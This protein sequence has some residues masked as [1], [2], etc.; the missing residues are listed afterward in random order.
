MILQNGTVFINKEF[1]P[2]DI[3]VENGKITAIMPRET[4]RPA[5]YK[6][7]AVDCTNKMIWPGLFDIHTHGCMGF[8][9]SKSEPEEILSMC[10]FYAEHGVT[11]ILATTM[12]N[13]DT[14]Y[15]RAMYS[16]RQAIDTQTNEAH[17]RGARIQG[18]HMEGPFFGTAKKGAHDEKYLRPISQTLVDEYQK[19]CGYAIRLFDLDPTLPG[20]IEFI[21]RNKE[22]FTISIAH[23]DC[24][25]KTALEAAE[26][27]ATHVTHLFNAMRPLLHREPGVVGAAF[28]A[29][30]NA[31]LICDGIHIHP[32]VIQLIFSAMPGRILLISDS[33]NPTGLSDG[34]YLAGGL[35][36]QVKDGR[37]YLADGTLAGSTITLFD[38]VKNAVHFHIPLN[39]ALLAATALPAK[40]VGLSDSVGQIACGRDADL[41]IVDESLT[42]ERVMVGGEFL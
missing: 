6:E 32:A 11:S 33:I 4:S 16:I 42:L 26:A 41:L 17:P 39:Q 23:T 25:Y 9:F 30:L 29:G 31:E 5:A 13:E 28:T 3:I 8:D 7:P 38:A 34:S 15:A 22:N 37:A 24:D 35:P 10:S 14:Q 2:A 12:T 1:I 20:A 40:A 36:I 21:R 19:R 18:I 27:G